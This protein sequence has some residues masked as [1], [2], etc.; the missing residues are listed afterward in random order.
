[1]LE[2]FRETSFGVQMILQSCSLVPLNMV[3]GKLTELLPFMTRLNSS[4]LSSSTQVKLNY[5][6]LFRKVLTAKDESAVEAEQ[7]QANLEQFLP[8][9]LHTLDSS[10]SQ[11]S[12]ADSQRKVIVECLLLINELRL[13]YPTMLSNSYTKTVLRIST[14]LKSHKKR[15]VRTVARTTINDWSLTATN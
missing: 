9:I 7:K 2:K 5:L 12:D 10:S 3:Q 6:F 1:M 15:V 13:M 14:K 4:E 8:Q 11:L